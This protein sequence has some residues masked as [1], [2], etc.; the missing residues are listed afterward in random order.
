MPTSKSSSN[1]PLLEVTVNNIDADDLCKKLMSPV[2]AC[3][4]LSELSLDYITESPDGVAPVDNLPV[5]SAETS[6]AYDQG[7]GLTGCDSDPVPEMTNYACL[8]NPDGVVGGVTMEKIEPE[9]LG[10]STSLPQLD[11]ALGRHFGP[12]NLIL[13]A[14]ITGGGKTILA[15]QLTADLVSNDFKVLLIS[16]EATGSEILKRMY[17]AVCEIPHT[18]IMDGKS[19]VVL[20]S[21]N[22]PIPDP[23]IYGETKAEKAMAL[24]EKLKKSCAFCNDIPGA[25]ED[26]VVNFQRLH[27][28]V[29]D[30]I[31]FDYLCYPE[32]T[33]EKRDEFAARKA[34]GDKTKLLKSIAV[35][36]NSLVIAFCQANPSLV[37]AKKILPK[38]IDSFK[39]IEDIA[40]AFVGMSHRYTENDDGGGS[41]Y[42]RI[43]HFSVVSKTK[44]Q[45]TLVPVITE[46]EY[47][48]FAPYIPAVSLVTRKTQEELEQ[49]AGYIEEHSEYPGY[50]FA[51]RETL[52]TLF[53][54]GVG[55]AANVYAFLLLTSSFKGSDIGS[56]FY[57]RDKI[58]DHLG[59]SSK[60]IQRATKE[61]IKREIIAVTSRPYSSLVYRFPNWANEQDPKN[62]GYFKLFHNLR[63]EARSDLLRDPILFRVWLRCLNKAR[64]Y[65]DEPAEKTPGEIVVWPKRDAEDLGIS[66]AQLDASIETLLRRGSVQ[67]VDSAGSKLFV[68]NWELYQHSVY[69]AH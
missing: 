35:D 8:D 64:W 69:P 16:T 29:P 13:F 31:I 48:R 19:L 50:V 36:Q 17:A 60:M 26:A 47:Q 37:T 21:V 54:C 23:A 38:D 46:F 63:D 41:P 18:D 66:K 34:V 2:E 49:R 32:D 4:E 53:T 61:L 22:L 24:V 11:A 27:G 10:F 57:G 59:L 25:L 42:E 15:G 44:P 55:Y 33:F 58:G 20:P 43:Q 30:V 39:S 6:G 40:D 62:S 3:K 65:E 14:G 12:G 68:S 28:R 7:P 45:P 9:G 52:T 1:S 67:S 56:S 51:R 5:E